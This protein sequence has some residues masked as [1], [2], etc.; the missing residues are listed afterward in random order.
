MK[1]VKKDKEATF[2][3]LD[4]ESEGGIGGTSKGPALQALHTLLPCVQLRLCA[5]YCNTLL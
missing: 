3:P 5:I 2:A 1:L 4:V